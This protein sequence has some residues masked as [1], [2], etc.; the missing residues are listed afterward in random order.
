M[1]VDTAD[2]HLSSYLERP[3]DHHDV[4][5]VVSNFAAHSVSYLCAVTASGSVR[6]CSPVS[7]VVDSTAPFAPLTDTPPLALDTF[8]PSEQ[9]SRVSSL[10]Q[11]DS[12]LVCNN[13]QQTGH[14]TSHCQQ[15][16]CVLCKG[17]HPPK[18]C[19]RIGPGLFIPCVYCKTRSGGHAHCRLDCPRA[20]GCHKCGSTTHAKAQC[21]RD[22]AVFSHSHHDLSTKGATTASTSPAT[23]WGAPEKYTSTAADSW[24]EPSRPSPMP[25]EAICR[26]CHRH[27]HETTDCPKTESRIGPHSVDYP[28]KSGS[29]YNDRP[30]SLYQPEDDRK[31]YGGP[32]RLGSDNHG[33]VAAASLAEFS[34]FAQRFD[35]GLHAHGPDWHT[36]KR[37]NVSA[38]WGEPQTSPLGQRLTITSSASD[39]GR[40]SPVHQ[41]RICQNCFGFGHRTFDC[42]KL[43]CILCEERH[44]IRDCPYRDKDLFLEPCKFCVNDRWGRHCR[45]DC[46][47]CPPCRRCGSTTHREKFCRRQSIASSKAWPPGMESACTISSIYFRSLFWLTRAS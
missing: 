4:D 9:S 40:M 2:E 47:R 6:S 26:N 16:P 20:P 39:Q 32:Q 27:G 46:E 23:D 18:D 35:P 10:P 28:D 33:A 31:A 38:D 22:G 7:D 19:N 12:H 1:D 24:G 34:G 3:S 21:G 5:S 30:A 13:C 11:P 42:Q 25:P 14:L 15:G 17:S 37:E 8:N 43:D 41:Q 45:A 36:V 29:R 44:R